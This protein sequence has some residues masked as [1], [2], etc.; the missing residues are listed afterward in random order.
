MLFNSYYFI[1]LFFPLTLLGFHLIS[2]TGDHLKVTIWLIGMSLF[3][4]GWWNPIY[5][6][7]IVTS[8]IINYLCGAVLIKSPKKF[9]LVFGIIFNLSLLSYFKYAHFIS[10]NLSILTGQFIIIEKIVLPLAIS[11]FT[12]QQ[13]TYLVDSYRGETKHY[14]FW[15]Y[16]L[17]VTFFPQLIAGP[18]VQHKEILP[19][20]ENK[21]LNRLNVKHLSIGI[22]LFFLGLFKKVIIADG[23][24]V[25]ATPVFNA[26]EQ[27]GSTLTF[28]EAWGGALAYSI[29]IYFD[30]SGYSDMAL[31][32]ARMLGIILP[33][34]FCSP[35]KASSIIDFWR[36]WH[37]T[38]SRFLRNYLYIPMGGNRKGEFRKHFNIMITM[39][40]AGLWH[41]DNWTF[42]IW[43]GLHACFLI[44]NHLWRL[45]LKKFQHLNV[46]IKPLKLKK[47]TRVVAITTGKL[48]TFLAVVIAWVIFR[49]ESL[50]GA[51]RFY[52]GMFGL[53]GFSIPNKLSPI[54]GTLTNC[55]PNIHIVAEGLGSFGSS[56]S[57]I[58]LLL[59]I[60]FS[61]TAPNTLEL[62]QNYKPALALNK[63]L[64]RKPIIFW[65][66]SRLWSLVI[67]IAAIISLTNLYRVSEFLYFQF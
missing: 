29:Q 62:M 35:Y 41:G 61:W 14:N 51:R 45:Y 39:L 32:L 36:R 1:F 65:K 5:I 22:T 42:V 18:I 49:C 38:L 26:A 6:P 53:N 58:T 11:F 19:Q 4:Y 30:F 67:A 60:L 59:L 12:F 66:P 54:L 25:K 21:L 23:I 63:E 48:I 43:G 47:I 34:N 8:I 7:L 37:M 57:I 20:L 33:A 27:I 17:F 50:E 52:E 56:S 28:F 46:N 16:T 44:I 10:S 3:F 55:F 31:G 13:I 24:A 9:F 40:L 15:N 2:K 64:I